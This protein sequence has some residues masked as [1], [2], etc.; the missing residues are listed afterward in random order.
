[1]VSGEWN[2]KPSLRTEGPLPADYVAFRRE[3]HGEPSDEE[4]RRFEEEWADVYTEI[5]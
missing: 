3:L 1:V 2:R 5:Q 4:V